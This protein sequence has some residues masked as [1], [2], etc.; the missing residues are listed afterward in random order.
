MADNNSTTEHVVNIE[1]NTSGVDASLDRATAR[2]NLFERAAQ[3]ASQ[4][5]NRYMS[6]MSG[7]ADDTSDAVSDM[8]DSLQ[9]AASGANMIDLS[10]TNREIQ[11]VQR[12]IDRTTTR[13]NNLIA[14][15]D[16]MEFLGVDEAS[17][18]FRALQYDIALAQD[19]LQELNSTQATNLQNAIASLRNNMDYISSHP[20]ETSDFLDLRHQIEQTET[21]LNRLYTRRDELSDLGVSESSASWRRLAL[22]ITN[23][24]AELDR[25]ERQAESMRTRG[26]A[27][28]I[29][30]TAMSEAQAALS[31]YQSRLEAAQRETDGY[32]QS[33]VDQLAEAQASTYGFAGRSVRDYTNMY[34]SIARG[35]RNL[36]KDMAKSMG[37]SLKNSFK[38]VGN[39]I[40]AVVKRI[41]RLKKETSSVSKAVDRMGKKLTSVF[42]QILMRAREL[43]ISKLFESIRE[44]FGQIATVSP[45]F[46]N[47]ISSMIDSVKAL[48]A[49]IV[50]IIEPLMSSLG[51]AIS[52]L[53]DLMTSGADAM[54]QFVA[55]LTGNDEY[56]KAKKGQSDYA[57]S[58][59]KTA[60][61]A[62]KAAKANKELKSSVLGFDELHKMT[63]NSSDASGIDSADLEKAV[64]QATALN[65]VADK[66]REALKT[67]N[68]AEL[69]KI[70]SDGVNKAFGWLDDVLGWSK[71]SDKFKKAIQNIIDG[72]NGFARNIDA[73]KIGKSFGNVINTVFESLK[74]ITD[75]TKG[76][77]FG[78]IGKSVGLALISAFEAINWRTI[79]T[80][81]VQ[82]IQSG[83]SFVNGIFSNTIIDA[84]TGEEMNL[85][86]QIGASLN[87]M[88]EGAIDTLN[89]ESW[90]NLV[91][92][93]VNNTTGFIAELFGDMSNV[94]TLAEKIGNAINTA[95]TS[96]DSEKLASA[97]SSLASAFVD[98]FDTLFNTISWEEVWDKL[99]GTLSSKNLDWLKIIEAI[100]LATL[101]SLIVSTLTTGLGGLGSAIASSAATI[102]GSPVVLTAV[103]AAFGAA[104][105]A[106]GIK[107]IIDSM[108]AIEQ[109]MQ[110]TEAERK[111]FEE[112]DFGEADFSNFSS[113]GK[114]LQVAG[115]ELFGGKLGA[116]G[117]Y[118]ATTGNAV[119]DANGKFVAFGTDIYTAQAYLD[120]FN[121]SVDG[122]NSD[123]INI[124]GQSVA[125]TDQMRSVAEHL[126]EQGTAVEMSAWEFAQ[127]NPAITNATDSI[128][129]FAASLNNNSISGTTNND[130]TANA[131]SIPAFASGGVVGD[132]QLFIANE[133]GAE[134]IGSDGSGNTAIVNNEQIISAV[135]TG[136]RQA[137]LE[138]G[139]SIADRVA[140]NSGG[141]GDTVIEIDSVEIARAANRGN[142]KIGR[143][144]NHN[145]TFA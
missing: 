70:I 119:E 88:F 50:A 95:I 114:S 23:T 62:N 102:A 113:F 18:S 137:V 4:L 17:S 30:T 90:G 124:D 32:T 9:H 68:F 46:N 133:G 77:R 93:L 21:A 106:Y 98:F 141:G 6:A 80:S 138:A 85:G 35:S 22:Q 109:N 73:G 29:D 130:S 44:S 48:G 65:T 61:S 41:S 91:A 74:M 39:T 69:G 144:E 121:Q 81:I 34:N 25:Y 5:F 127:L 1:A 16:R 126:I 105:S 92:N 75:P 86:E 13:L 11:S 116:A 87:R 28:G 51:G 140:E 27:T 55:R 97:V 118:A 135:V 134:L 108:P 94:T 14:R 103:A 99:T 132:G 43:A 96:I 53:V 40:S 10:D 52:Y 19:H 71:N 31:D 8:A 111:K 26:T 131:V 123:F 100:G 64:T 139:M 66:I 142:K 72:V 59:D 58:L 63:D 84:A 12:E 143:R 56:V 47:A 42:T 60:K 107:A 36:A 49:Q 112:S 57:K 110:E 136:V 33:Y 129:Q 120:L 89:P 79:G 67:G 3:R 76:I 38:S 7:S 82:S 37:N 104:G 20:I 122:L 78:D 54:S 2:L 128:Y 15:Q 117:M 24:E 145:V 45:S 101:P 125:V 83:I 115:A